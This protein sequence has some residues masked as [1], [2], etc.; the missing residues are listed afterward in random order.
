MSQIQVNNLTF[1]Y[2]GSYDTIFENTT[3][4]LDTDWRLGLIGRNGRGKTTLLKL[5]MGKYEYK[6]SIQCSA[7]F[8]YFPYET[9]DRS[10][11]TIEIIEEIYPDYE[12]WKICRELQ[13]LELEADILYRP[14]ETLSNGEQ[15]K[16]MLAALFSRDGH[17]LLIDEPVNHLDAA[18]RETVKEYLKGK[19]GFILVSHDRDFLDACVD[20]VLVINKSNIEVGQG[21]FSVWWENKKRQDAYERD[22]NER[23]KKEIARLSESAG[24]AGRWADDVEKTKIGHKTR[25]DGDTPNRDYIGEKSRRMQMRRKNLERRRQREIEEKGKLL[26]NV[27]SQEEI[28]LFPLVHYKKTLVRMEDIRLSYETPGQKEENARYVLDGFSLQVDAGE[29]IALTGPNGCGKSSVLKVILGQL[30]PRSGRIELAGGLVVSYVPQDPGFLKGDLDAWIED[31][32]LEESRFKTL[33]RKL[34]LES[35]QFHKNLED[36]SAG[37]KK[38]VLLAKSLLEKAHLYI[39]DEPLNYID[40][41]SRMQIEEL[42]LKY[43]PTLL[44]VEHDRTFMDK[45]ATKKKSLKNPEEKGIMM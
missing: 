3:F 9:G 4:R 33:L 38:K 14:F 6:G 20:H 1:Y 36:Y 41:F 17:F 45:M 13:L 44:F 35:V 10:R 2:D 40:I 21:N 34:D 37:Q 26:K 39:W 12:L 23:L 15:T 24:T 5:F 19:K 29:R 42:L 43:K 11:M 31:A 22:E 8:E 32:G 30:A 16:A 28:K 7:V 25:R 18:A 27:E